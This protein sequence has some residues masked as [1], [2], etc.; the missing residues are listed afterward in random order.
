MVLRSR[1]EAELSSYRGLGVKTRGAVLD[2]ADRIFA[3]FDPEM[4]SL[5]RVPTTALLAELKKR[6]ADAEA[7]ARD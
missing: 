6:K 4:P 1:L 3:T 7:R 5:A 2:A